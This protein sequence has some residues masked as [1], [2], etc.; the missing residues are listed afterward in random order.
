MFELDVETSFSA[1]HSLWGYLGKCE[2]CHG[3]NY[4]VRLTVTGEALNEIGLLCD[5]KDVKA[6]MKEVLGQLDHQFLNNLEPFREANPSAENI[7]R[8]LYLEIGPLV[9]QS[10]EYRAKV[11]R[12]KVWETE[13]NAVTYF[14]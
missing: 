11:S 13:R 8:Y 14:E 1:G 10:S 6:L 4:K 12:V 5:F 2:N 7:A 3:H 9:S